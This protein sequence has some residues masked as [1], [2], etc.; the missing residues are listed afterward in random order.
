ME[1]SE[2]FNSNSEMEFQFHFSAIHVVCGVQHVDP[3]MGLQFLGSNGRHL[4]F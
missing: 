2:T 1:G 4:D 3:K